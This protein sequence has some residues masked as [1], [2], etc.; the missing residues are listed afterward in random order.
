MPVNETQR[1]HYEYLFLLDDFL[2]L[3]MKSGFLNTQDELGLLQRMF[4]MH[5]L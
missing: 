4:Q 2:A 3:L 5:F 1:I